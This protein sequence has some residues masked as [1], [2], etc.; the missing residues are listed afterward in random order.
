MRSPYELVVISY[1]EIPD[2]VLQRLGP[3]DRSRFAALDEVRQRRF[4]AGRAA[5]LAAVECLL[6]GPLPEFAVDA[7]CVE[8][9][10]S[11]GRPAVS[12]VRP[13]VHVSIAHADDRAFAVAARSPVGVDAES[14]RTSS[15]RL[16]AIRALTGHRGNDLLGRW[17]AVEAILKADGRG[18]R[19]DPGAVLV[20]R[21]AGRVVDR[22]IRYRLRRVRDLDGCVVTIAWEDQADARDGSAGSSVSSS[23]ASKSPS[24]GA[25]ANPATN[26]RKSA[27][28]AEP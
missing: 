5:T 19:V 2:G 27:V 7:V 17:T 8:C 4:L 23:Q 3:S 14:R 1:D 26:A 24:S 12:G 13:D 28:D 15:A 6:G 20:E 16:Q 18:L 10:G 11:H 22:G 21:R 9:E 25:S